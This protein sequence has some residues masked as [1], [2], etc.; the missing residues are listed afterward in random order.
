MSDPHRNLH[1]VTAGL[2]LDEARA[3]MVL[4]HGRGATAESI[5]TLV[6]ELVA[7]GAAEGFAF[8]APQAAGGT[9]Y[10]LSFLAEI[11]RNEP[12]L[13]SALGALERLLG[14]VEAAGVPAERT[15][16]L[17]FSQGAC[18]AIEYTARHARR[19]GGVAVLTGGLIGPPG[20]PREYA[21]SFEGTP[22]VVGSGDPDPHVPRSRLEETAAVLTRMG[23]TVDLRIY[24][25]MGHTVNEEE[26]GLVR[27]MMAEIRYTPPA[28]RGSLP[29]Q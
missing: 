4:V 13:S 11:E 3:A 24:P 14:Q 12:Y 17:G 26:V 29:S 15:V 1:V 23:A 2:P 27:R 16:L 25:G 9:W 22:V 18:L 10:P 6:P 20:M 8:L 19:W 21:G 7:G 5:L 28:P